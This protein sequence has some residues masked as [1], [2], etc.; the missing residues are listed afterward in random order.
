[1]MLASIGAQVILLAFAGILLAIF[2]RSLATGVRRLTRLPPMLSL[3]A[4]VLAL[5]G[6]FVLFIL[7][8]APSVDEQA[9][10]LSR[11]I[12]EAIDKLQARLER[13]P[14]GGWLLSNQPTAGEGG[15]GGTF[16][17]VFGFVTTTLG[18]V[19]N[20]V[21]VLFVGLYLAA[22]PTLYL[23]GLLKLVPPSR[24]A[25][26]HQIVHEI[27]YELRWWLIGQIFAMF[28]IGV[29][30]SVGL[31][32]LGIPMA[33]ILG[34]I[35][36]L[37]NFVPNFGPVIA[38]LPAVLLALTTDSPGLALW[39]IGLYVAVQW[40]E[41]YLVTPMIQQ[42]NVDLPAALTLVTQVLMAL[43]VGAVGVTLATPLV[44][45][46]LVLVKM[47]YVEDVLGDRLAMPGENENKVKD[48]MLT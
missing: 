10:Q 27:G 11:R 25:R 21:L 4:V 17:Q 16:S 5:A 38:A 20:L 19:V 24:R 41:T 8:L 14:L 39:V 46:V 33:L 13:S 45:V 44:I 2:L 31:W 1:V 9:T 47:L 42:R 6:C 43:L 7:L 48:G 22:Q 34:L 29:L 12:P 26:A 32:V 36:G 35:A 40:F 28:L 30:V 23:D 15:N 37:L 3:A 18:N